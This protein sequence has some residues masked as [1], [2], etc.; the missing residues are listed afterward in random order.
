M[1]SQ[2][3]DEDAKLVTLAKGARIRIGAAEGAAVRDE[4]GRTYSGATVSAGDFQL[5]ALDLAVA[6]AIAA[7]ASGLECAV[8]VGTGAVDLGSVRE[9]A[10]SAVPV[11]S[12]GID[13]SIRERLTT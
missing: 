2:L 13:G 5:S 4:M 11:L 10:G 9:L 8:V 3:T 6:Q 12:C 7:G 1:S